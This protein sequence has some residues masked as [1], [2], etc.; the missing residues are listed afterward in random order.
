MKV[1][2]TF[3]IFF[4]IFFVCCLYI[5]STNVFHWNN[6]SADCNNEDSADCGLNLVTSTQSIDAGE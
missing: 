6:Y 4:V 3:F 2:I 5:V 1:L